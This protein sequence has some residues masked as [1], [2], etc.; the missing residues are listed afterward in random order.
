MVVPWRGHIVRVRV[1]YTGQRGL[2]IARIVAPA[3][4]VPG[5]SL[6]LVDIQLW[7]GVVDAAA[8]LAVATATSQAR[9]LVLFPRGFLHCPLRGL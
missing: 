4:E 6:L 2:S 7:Y 3:W 8:S 5:Q 9:S 1:G